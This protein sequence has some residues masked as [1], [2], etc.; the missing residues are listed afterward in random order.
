MFP[1]P[2]LVFLCCLVL[3]TAVEDQRFQFWKVSTRGCVYE[4]AEV[5]VCLLTAG[6]TFGVLFFCG[7]GWERE[8]VCALGF[9]RARCGDLRG[10]ICF[11]SITSYFYFS[12]RLSS[13]VWSY[14]KG[15][16]HEGNSALCPMMNYGEP[17]TSVCYILL[18][19][20]VFCLFFWTQEKNTSHP[21][22]QN[23]WLLEKQYN[24]TIYRKEQRYC[25]LFIIS[26]SYQLP[27]YMPKPTIIS[28]YTK[29]TSVIY[30]KYQQPR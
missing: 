19:T 28:L 16:S 15:V 18:N 29:P 5:F 14:G 8:A 30:H 12:P 3:I 27:K 10:L 6:G 26:Y 20:A 17:E 11:F 25:I 7:S 4:T 23:K 1:A 2:F 22:L 9:R 21:L 24:S 13:C